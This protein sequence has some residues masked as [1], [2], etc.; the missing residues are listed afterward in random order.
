MEDARVMCLKRRAGVSC[1]GNKPGLEPNL[2]IL[3]G[4]GLLGGSK[5][6]PQVPRSSGPKS[7]RQ[8]L[9]RAP[10]W[11]LLSGTSQGGPDAAFG[12]RS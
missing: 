4:F 9:D 10:F 6:P 11:S 2:A 8:A 5:G 3:G 7:A 12:R 1:A